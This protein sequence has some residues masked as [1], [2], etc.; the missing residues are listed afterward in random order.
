MDPL[1][2]IAAING[3]ITLANAAV[4]I[5]QDA[6]PYVKALYDTVSGKAPAD[7]TQAD[8]DELEAR[9][10]ALSDELQ[11]PLPDEI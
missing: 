9:I 6:A 7:V 3:A 2:I 1:S 5:G 4:K 11:A 10:D 8:L